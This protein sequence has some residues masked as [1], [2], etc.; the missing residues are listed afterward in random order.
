MSVKNL[1]SPAYALLAAIGAVLIAPAA[2]A[3]QELRVGL[4]AAAGSWDEDLSTAVPGIEDQT[5]SADGGGVGVVAQ[6]VV[7]SDADTGFF[8]GFEGA[9]TQQDASD[10]TTVTLPPLFSAD[11]TGEIVNSVDLLWFGG[12]DFGMVSAYAGVGPTLASGE[13]EI[14]FAGTTLTDEATHIGWKYG[15]GVEV[16][17]GSNVSVI[18][19][20]SYAGYRN[21]AYTA[22]GFPIAV[23]VEPRVNE[24]RVGVVYRVN[25]ADVLGAIGF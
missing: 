11:V 6:Y 2:G 5:L 10:T 18:A 17:L 12:Y 25:V 20:A 24:I 7:K 1:L 19:R 21:R 22:E 9:F 16:D 8:I 14:A 3:A 23:D 15:A 13:G 4:Q